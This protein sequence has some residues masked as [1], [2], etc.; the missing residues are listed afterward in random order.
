MPNTFMISALDHL[1]GHIDEGS[2]D[3]FEHLGKG[4][5]D[6]GAV[7]YADDG[8]GHRLDNPVITV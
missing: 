5:L 2:A 6:G 1:R 8:G 7:N 4:F 3:V